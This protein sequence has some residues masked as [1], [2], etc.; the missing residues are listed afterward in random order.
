MALLDATS[1]GSPS[2]TRLYVVI[3]IVALL[4][5]GFFLWHALR[6]RTEE[7][8]V[9]TFLNAVVAGDMQKAYQL[10]QPA[11]AYSFND[12]LEDWGP[13]GYYGPVKSY[14]VE[15][16]V[17]PRQSHSV[18]VEVLLSPY[19]PFPTSDPAKKSKTKK[20]FIW[21]N[22]SNQSLSFPPNL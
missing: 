22:Q 19:Q 14:R 21:V 11:P 3:A 6:F 2:K 18:A 20:L 10:W 16:S 9:K 8:T 12:F 7:R 13:N 17:E 1:Q 15:S 4:A 5:T